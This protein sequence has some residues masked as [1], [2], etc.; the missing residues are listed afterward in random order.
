MWIFL[1]FL[2]FPNIL[3]YQNCNGLF[4]KHFHSLF[5][6][7]KHFFKLNF[8]LFEILV[9]FIKIS[10]KL[11]Y[12]IIKQSKINFSNLLLISFYFK[13]VLDFCQTSH[14]CWKILTH[15]TKTTNRIFLNNIC[16]HQKE[17][18]FQFKHGFK[19]FLSRWWWRMDSRGK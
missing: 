9:S 3:T 5:A 11:Q 6:C 16:F 14:F 10:Q 13:F 19:T 1:N 15:A 4:N 8:E 7:L 17:N 12:S 18:V 2:K